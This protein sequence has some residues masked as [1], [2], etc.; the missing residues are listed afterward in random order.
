MLYIDERKTFF[1][2]CI[3][4]SRIVQKTKLLYTLWRAGYEKRDADTVQSFLS[5]S[6]ALL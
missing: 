2:L 3:T 5:G 6:K 1:R 4:N